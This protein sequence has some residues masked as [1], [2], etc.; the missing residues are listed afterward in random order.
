MASTRHL[1]LLGALARSVAYL[2]GIEHLEREDDG[3]CPHERQGFIAWLLS[4]ESPDRASD[5]TAQPQRRSF[6]AWLLA[7]E[8]LQE[9]QE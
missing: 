6:V 7:P 1:K 3:A 5:T 2:L 8:R 9:D 4:S